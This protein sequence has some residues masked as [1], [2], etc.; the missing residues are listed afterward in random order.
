MSIPSAALGLVRALPLG[1]AVPVSRSLIFIYLLVRPDVRAEINENYERLFG[2]R[3][4]RF[5]LRQG[6][7]LG[8]NLA[9]MAHLGRR[10]IDKSIDKAEVTGQ[11]VLEQIMLG[12]V[13]ALCMHFGPWELLPRLFARRGF[14]PCVGLAGQRDEGLNLALARLRRLPGVAVTESVSRLRRA[15]REGWLVGFVLDNTSRTRRVRCDTLW[16]GFELL[17]TPFTLGRAERAALVPISIRKD[18]GRLRV[19]VEEPVATPEEFG[20]RARAMIKSHP[21]DWVFWGKQN[22]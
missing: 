12:R 3:P 16:P 10:S 2:Q 21:E 13:I 8:E 9:W 22:R 4:G 5:W 7:R 6:W 14:R 1:L 19:R 18:G 15:V 11:N 17:R 20:V